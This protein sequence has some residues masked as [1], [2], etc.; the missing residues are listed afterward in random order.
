MI[1]QLSR[2]RLNT[3]EERTITRKNLG[4][5]VN[6]MIDSIPSP[7]ICRYTSSTGFSR[8]KPVSCREKEPDQ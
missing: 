4:V 2:I 3:P 6:S 7:R 8:R 5:S 1:A